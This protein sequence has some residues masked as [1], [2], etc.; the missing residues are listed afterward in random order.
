MNSFSHSLALVGH[1]VCPARSAERIDSATRVVRFDHAAGFKGSTGTRVD[2]LIIGNRGASAARLIAEPALGHRSVINAAGRIV[3]PFDPSSIFLRTAQLP[4]AAS[5]AVDLQ[6]L[7]Y[8]VELGA[9]LRRGSRPV[10]CIDAR[11]H[12]ACCRA[13]GL[14]KAPRDPRA[15][16][17]AG[18]EPHERRWRCRWLPNSALVA[19]FWY[20]QGLGRDWR[21]YLF[22][23]DVDA[24]PARL[25]PQGRSWIH[26]LVESGRVCV[27]SS[28]AE[29]A[30]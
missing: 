11:V 19:L 29:A 1:G 15:S 6:T 9:R 12:E 28:R 25:I 4:R 26:R 21:I 13:S 2:D 22:G 16:L 5:A 10:M 7:D 30:V 17:K 18:R 14:T 27:V 23:F 3:L 24:I 20:A 8:S